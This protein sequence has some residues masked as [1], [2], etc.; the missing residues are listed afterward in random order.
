M[1]ELPGKG[2]R[3]PSRGDRLEKKRWLQKKCCRKGG[4]SRR[5][6]EKSGLQKRLSREKN[7]GGGK[8]AFGCER[9][10]FFWWLERS[11]ERGKRKGLEKKRRSEERKKKRKERG[12]RGDIEEAVGR[13]KL[14]EKAET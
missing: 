7:G 10:A 9:G 5:V 11:R 12:T 8:G 13:E 6:A 4:C 3:K 1:E 14:I 2:S